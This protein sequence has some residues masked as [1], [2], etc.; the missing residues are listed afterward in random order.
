V[1]T[2]SLQDRA[3]L[4]ELCSFVQEERRPPLNL[5]S[6]PEA[7]W[8]ALLAR[9]SV[10]LGKAIFSPGS[11][12]DAVRALLR[13]LGPAGS[14]GGDLCL[15][16]SLEP[17]AVFDRLPPVTESVRRMGVK[18]IVIGAL[19]P[20][21]R[22]R[23]EG[24][25]TLEKNGFDLVLADGEEARECQYLLED[26]SKWQQKGIAILSAWAGFER[27][28]DGPL[29][30]RVAPSSQLIGPSPDGILCLAGNEQELPN[31]WT[32]ILDPES[33][34]A[35]AARRIIY[36]PAPAS[37]GSFRPLMFRDGRM[38]LGATLR[39][40]AQLG[41]ISV[42]LAPDPQLF[43]LALE[44]RLVD[45]LLAMVPERWDS[46]RLLTEL[47]QVQM[48][49]GG[50]PLRLRL[51]GARLLAPTGRALEARVELC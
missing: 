31:S 44:A 42:A 18:R 29:C 26:Y 25:K 43:R 41:I 14:N 45:S 11:E 24:W 40:L 21:P 28:S 49:E 22:H 50:N 33:R 5:G 34:A 30:L 15:F 23:G 6:R 16:V 3:H 48:A 35:P 38:D 7:S 27:A 46:Q 4:R 13:I 9:G 32:V 2:L 1:S 36:R 10:E 39:D 17:R 51:L 19:D 20:S 12:E 8:G 37:G 47:N